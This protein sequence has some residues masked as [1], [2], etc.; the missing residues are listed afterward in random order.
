MA[1]EEAIQQIVKNRVLTPTEQRQ[2]WARTSA[3][4][5]FLV[6]A[7]LCTREE[8]DRVEASCLVDLE[9]KLRARAVQSA[10]TGKRKR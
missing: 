2:L 10:T 8:F 9:E 6:K 7:G 3:V 5:H 1:S 4:R